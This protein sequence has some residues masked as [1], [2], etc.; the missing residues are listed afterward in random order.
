MAGIFLNG[1]LYGTDAP[2]GGIQILNWE[3]N[4]EYQVNDLVLH[5][6]NFYQCI[7]GNQDAQFTPS[8]WRQIGGSDGDYGIVSSISQLPIFGASELKLFYC[9]EDMNF[10]LWNGTTWV[11]QNKKATYNELGYIM[12]DEETLSVDANGK[13][14]IRTI[15]NQEVN[16]LF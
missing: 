8:K 2:I 3:A 4:T 11:S 1:K 7:Q 16:N 9:T 5:A 10:Y 13:L 15:T 12:V 14:S 6:Y